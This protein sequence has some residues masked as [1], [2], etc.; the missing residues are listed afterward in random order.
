MR[1]D[2]QLGDQEYDIFISYAREDGEWVRENLYEP[3]LRCRKADG[4]QPQV[5]LDIEEIG[6]R[7]GPN[8]INA[9]SKAILTCKKF[10]PIYSINY[11]RKPMCE[12]ELQQAFMHDPTGRAGK[13]NP[14]LIDPEAEPHVPLYIRNIH[15][16]AGTPPD[17][18]AGLCLALN[19]CPTVER[20]ALR[21]LDQPLNITVNITLSPL[22]VAVVGGQE[23]TSREVSITINAEGGSLE[24]TLTVKAENGIATFADLSIGAETTATRLIAIAEGYDPVYSEPFTVIKPVVVEDPPPGEDQWQLPRIPLQGEAVFFEDGRALA[25]IAPDQV[26][27]FNIAGKSLLPSPGLVRLGNRLR[28]MRR[29]GQALALADWASHVYVFLEDGRHYSHG[30]GLNAEGFV[31]PGDIAIVNDRVYVGF[32]NGSVYR[33]SFGE[34]PVVEFKHDAGVQALAVVEDRFYVCDFDGR[35]WVY[36]KGRKV[37]AETLDHYVRLL[38]LSDGRL[39]AVGERNLYQIVLN[40]LKVISEEVQLADIASVLGGVILPVVI[41]GRGKGVRFNTELASK[42]SFHTISGAMPISAD[43]AGRYTI[44]ANPDGSRTLMV[45]ERIVFTCLGGTLSVAPDG[46]R[47]ALGDENG[48]RVLDRASFESIVRGGTGVG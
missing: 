44:F 31:V 36:N 14:I 5:F 6:K 26:A 42:V 40:P 43:D 7:T 37:N 29:A 19:V 21:F 20:L 33:M 32:W 39:I 18:F 16:L 38:Q 10:V 22:R 8:F 4:S 9:L 23:T 2:M 25:V 47:F 15:Y 41:D 45:D 11:F 12:W 46:G 30:F 27:V 24:G 3:L 35:L 28:L 17:W 48:I 13:L 34:A 1:R